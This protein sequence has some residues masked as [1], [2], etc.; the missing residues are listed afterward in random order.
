[1]G[2]VVRSKPVSKQSSTPEK[3]PSENTAAVSPPR[4]RPTTASANPITTSTPKPEAC[5]SSP[6]P[7][8]LVKASSSSERRRCARR[9]KRR[10][11]FLHRTTNP[12][13]VFFLRLRSKKPG[14]RVA[15]IARVAGQ[16]WQEMTDEQRRKYID[17]ANAEKRRRKCRRYRCMLERSKRRTCKRKKGADKRG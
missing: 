3:A 13:L 12:F 2:N 15:K 17:L 9:E 4:S 7:R 8:P 11:D 6:S 16:R 14:V 1:M 5:P 10:R